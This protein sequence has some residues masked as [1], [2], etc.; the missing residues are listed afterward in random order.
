MVKELSTLQTYDQLKT[1]IHNV[2]TIG[3]NTLKGT[4]TAYALLMKV[5]I[6][7]AIANKHI[8]NYKEV[9]PNL[10][11]DDLVSDVVWL[12]KRGAADVI[13]VKN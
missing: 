10:P 9:N 8:F 11:H 3:T 13:L 4:V 7:D 1:I 5:E 12:M 2:E 6:K